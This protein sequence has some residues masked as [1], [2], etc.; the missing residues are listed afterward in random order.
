MLMM[1]VDGLVTDARLLGSAKDMVRVGRWFAVKVVE[2]W[3]DGSTWASENKS[4]GGW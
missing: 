2:M 3:K 1:L 4:V